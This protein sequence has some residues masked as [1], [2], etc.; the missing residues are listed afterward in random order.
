MA[1]IRVRVRVGGTEEGA[2][3]TKKRG[4]LVERRLLSVLGTNLSFLW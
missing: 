2:E 1:R 3:P 4:V